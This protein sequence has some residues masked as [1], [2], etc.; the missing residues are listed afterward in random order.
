[1]VYLD[2]NWIIVL[3]NKHFLIN[4]PGFFVNLISSTVTNG[5]MPCVDEVWLVKIVKING[6][7]RVSHY[8]AVTVG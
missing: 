7:C 4:Y 1:M 6:F 3:I 8:D 2:H 5:F